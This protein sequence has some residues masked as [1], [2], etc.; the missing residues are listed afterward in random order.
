MIA[1]GDKLL[2]GPQ[3]GLLLGRTETVRRLARF[4][5]ARAV[6]AD[7]LTLAALEATLRGGRPPVDVAL[8]AEPGRLRE[9]AEALAAA[10]DAEV[11][12]HD[13]RVG[14]GG[15]PGV[16]LHGWAVRLPEAVARPLRLGRP[17]VLPRVHD[18]A[19]LVDL[20]CVPESRDRDLVDAVTAALE[21]IR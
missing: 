4:P 6:R 5:L 14:G 16:P 15:A 20:R 18:G 8:H 2:G 21:G 13:G 19:C 1:S 9:R 3:A 17:A 10:V 12:P 7:K 11:V